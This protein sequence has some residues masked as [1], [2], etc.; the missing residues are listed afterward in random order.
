MH[1]KKL[2]VFT[3]FSLVFFAAFGQ[4]CDPNR[5]S[6]ILLEFYT[7]THENGHW[8]N[9]WDINKSMDTWFG[10]TLNEKGCVECID[11]DG[12]SGAF[13]CSLQGWSNVGNN[14]AGSLPKA[15]GDLQHLKFILFSGNMLYGEIPSELGRLTKLEALHLGKNQLSDN[16]PETLGN[17]ENLVQLYLDRNQLTSHVPPELGGLSKLEKLYLD[18]NQLNGNI[19]AELGDLGSLEELRLNNNQLMGCFPEE[20]A[21]HCASNIDFSNN[22]LLPWQGDFERFCNGEEHP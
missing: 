12:P 4:T 6:L 21:V 3:F 13:K 14:L 9:E 1:H 22:P 5:D 7:A 18:Q 10:V 11:M 16:I 17:L 2:F 8:D 15:L 19:P 20:L